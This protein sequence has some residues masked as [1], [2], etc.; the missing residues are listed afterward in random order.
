MHASDRRLLLACIAVVGAIG[1][2]VLVGHEVSG[3]TI[4]A[5]GFLVVVGLA[6]LNVA[7]R[8]QGWPKFLLAWT[9][10]LLSVVTLV[11]VT[12]T[13]V[14]DAHETLQLRAAAKA[15][16]EQRYP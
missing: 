8:A 2:L 9:A 4:G 14:T 7:L 6:S 13:G 12:Y 1:L 15:E 3:F 10:V 11:S 16:A 5:Y